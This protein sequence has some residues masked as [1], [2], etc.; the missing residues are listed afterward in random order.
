M[1][2]G[3]GVISLVES[4]PDTL[5][6]LRARS[7]IFFNSFNDCLVG[8]HIDDISAVMKALPQKSKL[9]TLDIFE[10]HGTFSKNIKECYSIENALS[11]DASKVVSL[12]PGN[13]LPLSGL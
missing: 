10:N 2:G 5:V 11:I 3:A 4:A 8:C 1:I 12:A 7:F 9:R 6:C 13:I